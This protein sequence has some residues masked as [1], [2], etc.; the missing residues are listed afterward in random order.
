M[1]SEKLLEEW[2]AF[3]EIIFPSKDKKEHVKSGELHKI[4]QELSLG[5]LYE[6]AET[7]VRFSF[8]FEQY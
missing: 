5:S 3:H 7:A 8:R 2:N 1:P 6:M 4:F